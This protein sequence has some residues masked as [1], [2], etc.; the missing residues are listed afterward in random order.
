MYRKW[1]NN[2]ENMAKAKASVAN[3]S[4]Q[5]L[6]GSANGSICEERCSIGISGSSWRKIS[7]YQRISSVA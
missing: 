5:Q 7:A 6:N 3:G 4:Q 2:I 1:R